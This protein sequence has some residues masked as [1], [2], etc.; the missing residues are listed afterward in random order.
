M[1]IAFI[2]QRY[3][4]EVVGG[5]ELHCRWIAEHLAEHHEV[6]VLS[7][8]A[9]E[10]LTWEN[11]YPGGTTWVNGVSV[12][13]FPVERQR[14]PGRYEE[15]AN[16]VCYSRHT[17]EEEIQWMHEHGP[18]CPDLIAY[19][20]AHHPDYNALIFFCY[21]YWT[22]YYGLRIAPEKSI[23]VPTAEHDKAI[24]L[25]IFQSMFNAPAA[26][27]YN[28]IEERDLIQRI[29]HNEHV[30]GEVVGV[31]INRPADIPTSDLAAKLDLLGDFALY[32][33]RIEPEKG[34]AVMID[35]FLRYQR[36]TSSPL[37][38]AMI[39]KSTM[40][41]EENV[42]ISLLGVTAEAEKLAALS[43]AQVLL[44]PS[45]HESLSMVLLEAWMMKRPVLVN[46][47]CEVLRGQVLRA[48]G[49]LYYR[50]FEEF[51]AGLE[52]LT[53]DS[54]LARRLGQQGHNYFIHN[55]SWDIIMQKYDR[56]IGIAVT[57]SA[58]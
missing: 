41:I 45:R 37:R 58:S 26:I 18:Y 3:G 5:A 31:G 49:G 52:L 10:Y 15:I 25:R 46:G 12:R 9:R 35:H 6:E 4:L 7:T 43:R 48:N 14:Q 11:D 1:K 38:L 17:D 33:G 50:S 53:N 24:Y 51:A 20:T 32:I 23:L 8:T 16:K 42:H 39:G 28:S 36:E 57:P 47:S 2:V 19:L 40:E 55:Y 34:V 44:M 29:A 13:R 21:R 30:P 22:S 56:L 54:K 27:A